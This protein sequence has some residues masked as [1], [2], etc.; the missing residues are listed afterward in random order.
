MKLLLVAL[1]FVGC[2]TKIIERTC[3]CRCDS[4]TTLKCS[5]TYNKT[6]LKY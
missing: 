2:S 1:L 5:D 6:E 4:N 3:E